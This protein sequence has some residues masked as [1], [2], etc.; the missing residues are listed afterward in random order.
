MGRVFAASPRSASQT[1]PGLALI[2]EIEHF[3]GHLTG[4]DKIEAIR[5]SRVN[6][7]RN[8]L[9]N[10]GGFADVPG[11]ELLIQLLCDHCHVVILVAY[12]KPAFKEVLSFYPN[13]LEHTV[14]GRARWL[15][16]G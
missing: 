1:S 12:P 5:I 8:K 13:R 15:T 16:H 4:R 2:E 14:A 9:F 6:D 7:L 11:F 3:L 10:L